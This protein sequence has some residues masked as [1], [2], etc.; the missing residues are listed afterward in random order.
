MVAA[1]RSNDV[2]PGEIAEIVLAFAAAAPL[3][4]QQTSS[5]P[6]AKR[7]AASASPPARRRRCARLHWAGKSCRVVR[8]APSRGRGLKR[9]LVDV[10]V[11]VAGRSLTGARIETQ[12]SWC[13]LSGR[14]GIALPDDTDPPP[15]RWGGDDGTDVAG[16]VESSARGEA[17]RRDLMRTADE[18][19]AMLELKRQGWGAKRIA[20]EFRTCPEDGA[21]LPA[22]GLH[23]HA[24]RPGAG[25]LVFP[26]G[27]TFAAFGGT[28][29][30][31]LLDNARALV[32]RHDA[33]TRGGGVQ[34]PAARF[35]RHSVFRPQACGPYRARTKGQDE[36]GVG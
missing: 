7:R 5:P 17:A 1:W 11:Q 2:P 15:F 30:E 28:T 23:G 12:R 31:V 6:V 14:H 33:A 10:A 20:R 32:E 24:F 22:G 16:M 21:T 36:R 34:R 3:A 29:E 18:V 8:V 9:R 13:S 4:D 26:K 27:S 35:A 19:T 25:E